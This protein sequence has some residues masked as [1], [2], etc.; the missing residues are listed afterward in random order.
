MRK[1]PNAAEGAK[2][3]A[4]ASD[5][6]MMYCPVSLLIL[7]ELGD[8]S[9]ESINKIPPTSGKAL[10]FFFNK[11]SIKIEDLKEI[12]SP[13]VVAR[14]PVPLKVWRELCEY[15]EDAPEFNEDIKVHLKP[16]IYEYQGTARLIHNSIAFLLV[17]SHEINFNIDL[18]QAH[19]KLATW[20]WEHKETNTFA[21]SHVIFHLCHAQRFEDARNL[22]LNFAWNLKRMSLKST[23]EKLSNVEQALDDAF[24]V[25]LRMKP[26]DREV[27]IVQTAIDLGRAAI[28]YDSRQLASQLLGRIGRNQHTVRELLNSA[29]DYDPGVH[30]WQPVYASLTRADDSLRKVFTQYKNSV[31]AVAVSPKG[32]KIATASSD[33]FV[34]IY[35][36]LRGRSLFTFEEH[37]EK[38]GAVLSVAF[39]HHESAYLASCATD[40]TVKIWDVRRGYKFGELKFNKIVQAI[41]FGGNKIVDVSLADRERNIAVNYLITGSVDKYIRI[42]NFATKELLREIKHDFAINDLKFSSIYEEQCAVAGKNGLITIYDWK[43][44]ISITSLVA[45]NKSCNSIAYH[46]VLNMLISVSSDLTRGGGENCILWNLDSD[47]G[48]EKIRSYLVHPS[49]IRSVSFTQDGQ[50]FVTAGDDLAI[51]VTQLDPKGEYIRLTHRND[52]ESVARQK[53]RQEAYSK[54]RMVQENDARTKIDTHPDAKLVFL[55]AHEKSILSVCFFPRGYQVASCGRDN[56]L[57]IWSYDPLDKAPEQV[58]KKGVLSIAFSQ[59][60]DR[61]CTSGRDGRVLIWDVKT[62]HVQNVTVLAKPSKRVYFSN[63]GKHVAIEQTPKN[64]VLSY[65]EQAKKWTLKQSNDTNFQDARFKGKDKT[66][67]KLRAKRYGVTKIGENGV[68]FTIDSNWIEDE[69]TTLVKGIPGMNDLLTQDPNTEEAYGCMAVADKVHILH[70]RAPNSKDALKQQEKFEEAEKLRAQLEEQVKEARQQE[71]EQ[72]QEQD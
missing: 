33:G 7:D 10:A 68:D 64:F 8:Y 3:L 19:R 44:N 13:L 29:R 15:G 66:G 26:G 71:Q 69:N 40:N 48:E 62:G 24:D 39:S 60:G 56:Q 50:H 17:D 65:K 54:Q 72:E 58:H 12:I 9:L 43:E 4:E 55:A 21:V 25:Y 35:E 34:R 67:D 70:L 45:H 41:A 32:S 11:L 6:E 20:C 46:P 49:P 63:D 36:T 18:L 22:L 52:E 28:Q 51:C 30:W 31:N 16:L 53:E 14:S 42:Y 23:Y 2:V 37:R 47:E 61:I 5:G 27:L 59:N 38:D 1:S 57:K